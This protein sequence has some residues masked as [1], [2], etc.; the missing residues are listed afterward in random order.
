VTFVDRSVPGGRDATWPELAGEPHGP[1]ADLELNLDSEG[2]GS[3]TDASFD[4]AVASHVIEHL[5]N[6]LAVMA[7][8]ARVLRPGGH[9][10]LVVPDRMLTFDAQRPG[11]AYAHL[12][13]EFD[14]GVT[15][16][17]DEH[18]REFCAAIFSQPPIHP[19]EVREWHDPDRLDAGRLDL[20]RRRSVHA[21]CWTPEEFA[22][23]VAA[24]IV[25][26]IMAWQLRELYVAEDVVD[27]PGI[28]FG[29]VLER[30]SQFVD[31]VRRCESFVSDWTEL[32]LS[33]PRRDPARVGRFLASLHR[34]LP[35]VVAIDRVATRPA[36]IMTG[37]LIAARARISRLE[38][39]SDGN[40]RRADDLPGGLRR[41]DPVPGR[42]TYR[43]PEA[44][45]S[46]L[47]RLRNRLRR[48]AP[49]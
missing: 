39:N 13:A 17:D 41:P 36:E 34:D 10:V 32:V 30:P 8:M 44:S 38:G 47:R 26:D 15:A 7:E 25:D 43:H 29:L 23:L 16:V 9:L 33:H 22:A 6:P 3:L 46:A 2:L 35:D 21:H 20:H 18:I 28:E 40:G 42:P 37:H 19:P 5:A 11:T 24:S 49:G 12:R 14:L 1:Q 4:A 48:A 27:T 45:A 31:P